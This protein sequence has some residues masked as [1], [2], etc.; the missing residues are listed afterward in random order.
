M[1]EPAP[2][3]SYEEVRQSIDAK[4]G[5]GVG[6]TAAG[7]VRQL[8]PAEHVVWA[9]DNLLA[10]L[11]DFRFHI[12]DQAFGPSSKGYDGPRVIAAIASVA[13]GIDPQVADL[14][15]WTANWAHT[16]PIPVSSVVPELWDAHAL[17]ARRFLI[18]VAAR[19]P[20]GLDPLGVQDL[21][22][23]KRPEWQ[24][25]KVGFT[26]RGAGCA[27]KC[28]PVDQT[29]EGVLRAALN[30]MWQAG[31]PDE[32]LTEFFTAYNE[33]GADEVD[34]VCRYVSFDGDGG[35]EERKK[36]LR[37]IVRP[38]HPLTAWLG[39]E[40]PASGAVLLVDSLDEVQTRLGGWTF[41]RIEGQ[42]GAQ[43]I[44]VALRMDPDVLLV[45]GALIDPEVVQFIV[46]ASEAGHLVFVSGHEA[47]AEALGRV[48]SH[49]Q[50]ID[51]R[52]N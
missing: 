4:L 6:M 51:R 2:V 50:V 27:V 47:A 10:C 17:A 41:R 18:H 52:R 23:W 1:L 37:H 20:E 21:A 44:R 12:W 33:Q 32:R 29:R 8:T 15:A 5:T 46:S 31:E 24:P 7:A 3:R 34:V 48:P 42:D 13:R 22:P 39:E 25:P 49:V 43:G 38:I 30:A 11:F 35:D 16:Q 19:W 26:P 14:L 36:A 28:A 9:L 40:P 45:D